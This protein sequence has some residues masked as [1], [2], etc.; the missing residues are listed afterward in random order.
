MSKYK[1]YKIKTKPRTPQ[2]NACL[3]VQT[4]TNSLNHNT[5]NL[6][7][8]SVGSWTTV[9]EISITLLGA[10]PWNTDG[11]PTVSNTIG[12]L[13]NGTGLVSSG[14]TESVVVTVNSNVLL[15]TL[16]ELVNSSLDVL[17]ATLI[18]HSIS[19][20]VGMETRSVPV[21]WDWLG[22]E[23][24]LDTKVLS[25]SVE[26]VTGDPKFVAHRNSLAWPNLEFPLGWKNLSVDT[27]NLDASVQAS[28]VVSLNNVTAVD[29]ASTNTTVVWPL[30]TGETSLWS[31]VWVSIL[32]EEG[33]FLLK[34][35]PWLL[36]LVGLHELSTIV[37][38]VELVWGTIG[39]PAL[40]EN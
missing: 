31:S 18:S 38:V 4:T 6:V 37:S 3:L 39:V 16:G 22:V 15:V 29:F 35:K 24:D 32:V 27:R 28:L 26:E 12:E 9:F 13:I 36:V 23:G 17:H 33:I 1:V 34:T 30:R 19:G 21:T 7:W 10:R 2:K 5:S 40:V 8:A 14:K 20:D 25:N 11:R